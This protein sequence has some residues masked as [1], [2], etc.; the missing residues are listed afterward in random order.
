MPPS[1]CP[2]PPSTLRE[3]VLNCCDF[4]EKAGVWGGG[5][6]VGDTQL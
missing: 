5:A 4:N 6:V 1:T 3:R 2:P